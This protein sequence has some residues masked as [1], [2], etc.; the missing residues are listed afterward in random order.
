M[1]ALA[2]EWSPEKK[3]PLVLQHLRRMG[4]DR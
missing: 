2:A 4:L 3:D 1:L